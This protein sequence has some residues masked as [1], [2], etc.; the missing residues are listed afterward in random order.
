MYCVVPGIQKMI[1]KELLEQN[2]TKLLHFQDQH[3]FLI[4]KIPSADWALE[5][6][7]NE[8]L[9]AGHPIPSANHLTWLMLEHVSLLLAW[10]A[11]VLF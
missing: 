10:E 8:D 11:D 2:K 1:N 3:K 4:F 5:G 6:F 9:L 7:W